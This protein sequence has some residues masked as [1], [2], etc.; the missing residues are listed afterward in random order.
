MRMQRHGK[1]VQIANASSQFYDVKTGGFCT[2]WR[3]VKTSAKV[4]ASGIGSG[5]HSPIPPT[6]RDGDEVVHATSTR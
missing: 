3:S 1:K 6:D 2:F 5:E 4:N